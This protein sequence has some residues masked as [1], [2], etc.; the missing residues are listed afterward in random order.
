MQQNKLY[1]YVYNY[2]NSTVI[3]FFNSS[4]PEVCEMAVS[5]FFF[6]IITLEIKS[7]KYNMKF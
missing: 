1:F 6:L 7:N 5:I 2:K 3:Y 4:F